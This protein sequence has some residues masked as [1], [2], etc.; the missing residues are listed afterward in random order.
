VRAFVFGVGLMLLLAACS[1]ISTLDLDASRRADYEAYLGKHLRTERMY[2]K[3][4]ETASGKALKVTGELSDLQAKIVPGF[5][6]KPVEGKTIFVISLEM[7]DWSRFSI[8]DFKFLWGG[9]PAKS[10]KEIMDGQ[11]LQ[12]LYPYSVPH[13]RSFI[14]EFDSIAPEPDL[15]KVQTSQGEFKFSFG[16]GK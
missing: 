2:M 7:P 6:I 9:A 12:T 13:D 3:L 15:L 1:T 5:E 11:L 14:V 16:E 10:V 8:A 4:R